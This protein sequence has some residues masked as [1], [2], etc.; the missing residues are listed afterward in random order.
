MKLISRLGNKQT[1]FSVVGVLLIL[2]IVWNGL[3]FYDLIKK[4]EQQRMHIWTAAY[5]SVNKAEATN[6][7]KD[8]SLELEIIKSNNNIPMLIT[9]KQDSILYS[10][11][12]PN[13]IRNKP[14]KIKTYFK[15]IKSDANKLTIN[16]LD[17]NKQYVYYN[18]SSVLTKIKWYPLILLIIIILFSAIAYYF[19]SASKSSE[20]NK[21]WAGMAKETAHQI[22]T[23]LS[24]LLGWV[25]LLKTDDAINPDYVE[26]IKKD[27][28][29]LQTISHR[30]SKV[31]SQIE[32][33]EIDIVEVTQNAINYLKS[34]SSKMIEFEVNLPKHEI[35][36]PLNTTL[37]SWTIENLTKNATDAMSGKG[38]LRID[39]EEDA[40]CV[41]VYVSDT[42]KGIAANLHQKIFEP[43]YTEKKRGWGLGLSLAK[44]IIKDYHNG[45]I[46]VYKSTPRKGTTMMIKFKK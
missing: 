9:N 22:G 32:L 6:T 25:E 40:K 37:Y 24:S 15:N 46:S 20:Q 35:K 36:I 43:G 18:E 41:K 23:P 21:L 45:N 28:E 3:V 4:D 38:Q 13:N 27:V 42:G 17:G 10:Q 5:Q 39:L 29:R 16:L 12:L 44:R 11:N 33:E 19:Y 7:A 34:R 26:E 31:G 30:F 2:L 1:I 8:L 14:D